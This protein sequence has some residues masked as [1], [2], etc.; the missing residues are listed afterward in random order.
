MTHTAVMVLVSTIF[1][2][3]IKLTVVA[4]DDDAVLGCSCGRC[5][6]G[7]HLQLSASATQRPHDR[8]GLPSRKRDAPAASIAR[9]QRWR[10]CETAKR[11]L[12]WRHD[13]AARRARRC[14]AS[15]QQEKTC[16]RTQPLGR[17]KGR[18][19]RNPTSKKP[20][21][22]CSQPQGSAGNRSS[23][24]RMRLHEWWSNDRCS[25]SG[26]RFTPL[27]KD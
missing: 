23:R 22:H 16:R 14:G 26:E 24:V 8:S 6:L 10:T 1:A 13:C 5:W 9:L 7:V 21:L 17:H 25:A 3:F 18:E 12:L 19:R 15:C 11:C 4:N 20:H 2:R 27:E